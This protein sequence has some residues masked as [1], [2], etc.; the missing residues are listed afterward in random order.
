MT[1]MTHVLPFV[2][3]H[4]AGQSSTILIFS[5]I[6]RTIL[7]VQM[8]LSMMSSSEYFTERKFHDNMSMYIDQNLQ[9]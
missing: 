3:R 4:R 6:V 2:F 7:R 5:L 1:S 9:C 8:L